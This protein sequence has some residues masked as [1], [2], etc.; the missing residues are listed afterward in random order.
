MNL[1]FATNNQH[2]FIE[3]RKILNADIT[4]LSLNDIHCVDELP[5]TQHTLEGNAQ[6]KASYVYDNFGYN[7]FADDTGLEI[8]ALNGRPGVYSARYAGQS[9]D[10]AENMDKVIRELRN[11]SNRRARFRTV[12]AVIINEKNHLFE[13]IVNGQIL[14]EKRGTQGFGY[15]PIFLPDGYE[16]SFAQMNLDEKNKI[17]HRG[18]AVAELVTYL[19]NYHSK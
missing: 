11:I 6:Q 1:V 7:C 12:I 5:E 16:V 3:I 2:K 10:P 19:N 15:D 17:S 13:G 9:K 8:E 4:L 18:K 14:S